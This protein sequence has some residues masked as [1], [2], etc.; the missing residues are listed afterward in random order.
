MN[1]FEPRLLLALIVRFAGGQGS[2]LSAHVDFRQRMMQ[3]THRFQEERARPT[4]QRVLHPRVKTGVR[5]SKVEGVLNFK[6]FSFLFVLLLVPPK[7]GVW[8]RAPLETNSPPTLLNSCG[9]D[10][11][12]V[13]FLGRHSAS[14]H[15]PQIDNQLPTDGHHRFFFRAG[16]L[17]RKTSCHFWTG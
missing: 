9:L 11:H 5:R 4:Y 1:H 17:P 6:I 14:F 10:H 12:Q 7:H 15:P 16:L 3:Y 8:G 2:L 13:E